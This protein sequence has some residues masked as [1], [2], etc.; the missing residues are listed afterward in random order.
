[1]WGNPEKRK[2]R[3][4]FVSD[5]NEDP[6]LYAFTGF[7]ILA[8]GSTV[9][10]CLS[11]GITASDFLGMA[12]GVVSVLLPVL[13][14]GAGIILLTKRHRNWKIYTS[15]ILSTV[16]MSSA[17]TF[18]RMSS[19]LFSPLVWIGSFALFYRTLTCP[20]R[21]DTFRLSVA[22]GCIFSAFL[23][24]GFQLEH[25]DRLEILHSS[26]SAGFLLSLSGIGITAVAFSVMLALL[27]SKVPRGEVSL[28]LNDSNS[29]VRKRTFYLFGTM[30]LLC[31]WMVYFI[32][33]YP[34]CM[35]YDSLSELN[36]QLYKGMMTNHHPILHQMM[37]RLFCRIGMQ[38]GSLAFGVA[39]YS[40]FQMFL[41]AFAFARAAYCFYALGIGL[42]VIFGFLA[43][44]GLYTVNGYYSIVMWKD[45]PFAAITL[46]LCVELIW[47]LNSKEAECRFTRWVRIILFSFLF[48][49]LRNNGFFAFLLGFPLLIL[50]ADIKRKQLS[51]CYMITI[52]AFV[53]YCL[54]LNVMQIPNTETREMLS[55]PVQQI[56]R[57]VRDRRDTLTEED[58]SVLS[59]VFDDFDEIGQRYNPR[60]SDPVKDTFISD[61]FDA[62]PIRYAIIW[63]K[64]AIRN[65][66]SY[67]TAFLMQSYGYWY[68][69]AEYW[70]IAPQIDENSYGLGHLP[71]RSWLRE[72]LETMH[73]RLAGI[74]PTAVFYRIGSYLWILVLSITIL[75]LS[76][77]RKM[78][79][80]TC[81]LMILWL[82]NLAS[83]VHAE[84]RYGYAMV[85]CMPLF[86]VLAA[87][88][89]G[90]ITG[91][92]LSER[93]TK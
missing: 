10:F 26:T 39:L 80:P 63:A 93:R 92:R 41:L 30:W 70:L 29:S 46:L 86:A 36:M 8:L 27:F 79:A 56:A 47:E 31:C 32:A 17:S 35:T 13:A 90:W 78:A 9:L 6:F 22:L 15:G 75:W 24:F 48:C 28:E 66:G 59:E 51:R 14:A 25:F 23:H 77:N 50:T 67:L 45:I 5:N 54:V 71:E 74:Y 1:M 12:K 57:T 61:V 11:L 4:H 33:Y 88:G 7:R 87:C 18:F 82:T 40:A 76:G 73:Y 83:P 58:Y 72:K 53:G 65:P 81:P 64:L 3:S 69:D 68:P 2:K 16:C 34:G 37:I 19:S 85:V 84:F 52:L 43:V 55:V 38:S 91:N 60:L 42:P 44:T 20:L 21:R 89:S 49:T 62:N